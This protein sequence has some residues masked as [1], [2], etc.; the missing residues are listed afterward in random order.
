MAGRVWTRCPPS[1]A[2]RAW[3]RRPQWNAGSRRDVDVSKW[4]VG[5]RGVRL[6]V[7][8]LGAGVLGACAAFAP[9]WA[10]ASTPAATTTTTTSTTTATTTTTPP[11]VTIQTAYENTPISVGMSDAIGYQLANPTGQTET[12]SFDD[13]LPFGVTVDNPAA[14]TNTAGTGTCALQSANASP[15]AGSVTFTV[16]VPSSTAGG[17]VCTISVGIVPGAP[18]RA[19][20]AMA[21]A[22]SHVSAS[23]AATVTPSPAGLVVLS[24]PTLS[25]TAPGNGQTLAL[26]QVFDAS[27][28]C[29]TT[30]PLDSIDSFFGTD[31]EGNQIEPGGPI[32]TV[33]PGSHTL[34]VDC[35]SAAGGGSVSATVSY[36]VRSYTVWRVRS[37]RSDRVSFR[38]RLPAGKL[39]AILS[40]ADAV[41]TTT[42]GATSTRTAGAKQH[43]RGKTVKRL[44]AADAPAKARV[45][46]KLTRTLR[47]S[48]RTYGFTIRPTKAGRR[49]ISAARGRNLKAELRISFTPAPVGSGDAEIFPVGSIVVNKPNVRLRLRHR[50]HGSAGK[51]G[52]AGK[53]TGKP[54]KQ[55][56]RGA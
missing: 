37:T 21:D 31:D 32:D 56:S 3:A 39:V 50:Q 22:Y 33:D 11:A 1:V 14:V 16:V 5:G 2:G 10:S 34:E 8:G 44:G 47:G 51:N 42:T 9:G 29:A 41:S 36:S 13:Q 17:P 55:R 26:G 30:D 45:I 7:A 4:L 38:S 15:G 52:S 48:A 20:G 28:G 12:V 19:D 49:L 46:G 54:S 35:Y 18:S 6:L 24:S 43:R 25:F 53:H 40:D 23:P 27:F